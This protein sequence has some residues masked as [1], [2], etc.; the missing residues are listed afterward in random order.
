MHEHADTPG[1]RHRGFA[2]FDALHGEAA[3]RRDGG[4]C[5]VAAELVQIGK[6]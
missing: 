4:G 1:P 5:L 6:R 2:L 3:L